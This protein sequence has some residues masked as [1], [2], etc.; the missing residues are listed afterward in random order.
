MRTVL[1][2]WVTTE[3]VGSQARAILNQGLLQ[4]YMLLLLSWEH[5]LFLPIHTVAKV[6]LVTLEGLLA[7]FKVIT[8]A[9]QRSSKQFMF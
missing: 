8:H 1:D 7:G 6:D 4:S 3:A 2:D 9:Q 5:C